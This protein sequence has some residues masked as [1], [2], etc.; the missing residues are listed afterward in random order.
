MSLARV[1]IIGVALLAAV[2]AGLV[3]L[4]LSQ[5]EPQEPVIITAAPAQPPIRLV[6]VLITKNEVPMGSIVE[7]GLAW[8]KWPQDGVGPDLIL[9]SERPNATDEFHGSIARQSFF[10]GEPVRE[11]KLIKPE[12]GFLSAILS[13]GKRAVSVRISA[14]TAAGGFILPNDHVDVIMTRRLQSANGRSDSMA[15]ET[16]LRN[17]RVLAID[18]TVQEQDGQKVVVGNVATLEVDPEQAEALTAAQ[19]MADRFVLS[20]RSLA[21][22][23]PGTPGYAKFLLEREKAQRNKIRVVRYGKIDDVTTTQ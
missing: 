12:H 2:G 8:Q 3:A 16:V 7:G 13:E 22:S 15:T 18:Q 23:I 11:S 4:N 19:Q 17:L 14:E 9:K 5:P 10:A 6:D 1:A 21:D 20:L